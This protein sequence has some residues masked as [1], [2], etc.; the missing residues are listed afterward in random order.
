MWTDISLVL[1]AYI[2]ASIPFVWGLAKLKNVDLKQHGSRNIGGG[3]LASAAGFWIGFIG[4]VGDFSKGILPVIIGYCFLEA[5]LTTLC[6]TA[7]ASLTGQIWPV[8]LRFSG[9]RGSSVILGIASAFMITLILQ[10]KILV[11]LI[12]LL[13]GVAYR[14]L[15]R[16]K[17]TPTRS[18]PLGAIISIALLPLLTWV[19]GEPPVIPLTFTVI[20]LLMLLRRLTADISLDFPSKP[21]AHQVMV[22]LLNRLLYDRSYHNQYHQAPVEPDNREN[23]DIKIG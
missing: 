13:I 11:V 9:G 7:I 4:S 17:K 10:A 21:N 20:L 12:P 1:G 22:I 14:N 19:W 2:Y 3:N 8:F 6:L 15:R 23:Y 5:N 16:K 18:V